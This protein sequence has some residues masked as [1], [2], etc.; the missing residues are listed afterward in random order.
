MI[1]PLQML[2]PSCFRCRFFRHTLIQLG[3]SLPMVFNPVGG[4]CERY[5]LPI[6]EARR[7]PCGGGKKGFKDKILTARSGL[8]IGR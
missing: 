1:V 2:K 8:I 6:A 5:R 7:G 3:K 4:F